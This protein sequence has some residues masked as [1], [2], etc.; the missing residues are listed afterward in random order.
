MT[1][2]QLI[3]FLKANL[4]LTVNNTPDPYDYHDHFTVNLCLGDEVISQIVLDI[5][6]GQ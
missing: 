6:D 3:D 1:E 5:N 2:E 4:S